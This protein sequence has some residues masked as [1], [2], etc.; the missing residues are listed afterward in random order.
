MDFAIACFLILVAKESPKPIGLTPSITG[1]EVH[2]LSFRG[3]VSKT[4]CFTV[5]L[6]LDPFILLLIKGAKPY[7]RN[8]QSACQGQKNAILDLPEK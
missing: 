7:P 4:T 3:R 6:R 2:P 1:V 5:F 8:P